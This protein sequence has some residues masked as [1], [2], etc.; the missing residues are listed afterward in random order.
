MLN[1]TVS[2]KP[3]KKHIASHSQPPKPYLHRGNECWKLLTRE[4]KDEILVICSVVAAERSFGTTGE[5]IAEVL[6]K[7][8]TGNGKRCT[9]STFSDAHVV[10]KIIDK[11]LRY[12][13]TEIRFEPEINVTYVFVNDKEMRKWGISKSVEKAV[14]DFVDALSFA[15]AQ[16]LRKK[17]KKDYSAPYKGV[18][19]LYTPDGETFLRD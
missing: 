14:A 4:I 15:A 12:L 10:C 18:E 9:F 13:E 7:A 6:K 3:A 2:K 11:K 8:G 17:W 19:G 16:F 1:L 5:R